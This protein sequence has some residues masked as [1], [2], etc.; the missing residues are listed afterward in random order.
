[1]EYIVQNNHCMQQNGKRI[2]CSNSLYN[3]IRYHK[4]ACVV[5]T[6]TIHIWAVPKRVVH[7][8]AFLVITN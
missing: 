3:R 6:F 2:S 4:T 7:R 5:T 8:R 1:M